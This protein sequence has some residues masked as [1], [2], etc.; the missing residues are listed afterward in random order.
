MLRWTRFALPLRS[1]AWCAKA[2][3][4]DE[5]LPRLWVYR[6]C[7]TTSR[8]SSRSG[9]SAFSSGQTPTAAKSPAERRWSASRRTISAHT[10]SRCS[11][12]AWS[13]ARRE[14]LACRSYQYLP[15]PA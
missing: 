4:V 9:M 5:A 8:A 2:I 1:V 10:S 13:L 14:M 15:C 11:R 7:S 12:S 6:G 3:A